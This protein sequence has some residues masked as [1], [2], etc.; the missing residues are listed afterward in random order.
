MQ[1]NAILYPAG[2]ESRLNNYWRSHFCFVNIVF[3]FDQNSKNIL[4]IY[5]IESKSTN[6]ECNFLICK[7]F[8]N[9]NNCKLANANP[10]ANGIKTCPS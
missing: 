2:A 7:L 1:S 10:N 9:T 8:A 4:E 6:L 5:K 3:N